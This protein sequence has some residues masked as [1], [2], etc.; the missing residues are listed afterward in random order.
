M[1]LKIY[2]LELVHA[3]EVVLQDLIGEIM[4]IVI[5]ETLHMPPQWGFIPHSAG[6]TMFSF[7]S[8]IVI[9][10]HY[11]CHCDICYMCTIYRV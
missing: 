3:I 8:S 7:H 4:S 2:R 9:Q 6:V 11:L 1:R 10:E 5:I